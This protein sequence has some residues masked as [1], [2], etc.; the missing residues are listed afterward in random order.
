MVNPDI[1]SQTTY[2]GTR[3]RGVHGIARHVRA[4]QGRDT[5]LTGRMERLASRSGFPEALK[6]ACVSTPCLTAAADRC[7]P[8]HALTA[9]S[10]KCMRLRHG[11]VVV[12]APLP[13]TAAVTSR[14]KAI[15]H[16]TQGALCRQRIWS[17]IHRSCAHTSNLGGPIACFAP[18]QTFA[19]PSFAVEGN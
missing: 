7:T 12:T 13:S 5:S 15:G 10:A 16:E 9:P 4:W 19:S 3:I 6:L 1:R 8:N 18:A 2:P 11:Q 17:R 14:S